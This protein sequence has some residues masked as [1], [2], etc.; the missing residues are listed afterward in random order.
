[1]NDM[2]V[3]SRGWREHLLQAK[4]DIRQE[5]WENARGA[6]LVAS[7]LRPG[8]QATEL[9]LE[10]V[11]EQAPAA[12]VVAEDDAEEGEPVAM[13]ETQAVFDESILGI[14]EPTPEAEVGNA[15]SADLDSPAMT[16]PSQESE[17]DEF[18]AWAEDVWGE[19]GEAPE[20]D[21]SRAESDQSAENDGVSEAPSQ[22]RTDAPVPSFEGDAA[23]ALRE[24][25]YGSDSRE[26]TRL[27]MR[28]VVQ[29]GY[30]EEAR[31]FVVEIL[32]KD[33][34]DAQAW[35][36]AGDLLNE[37]GE[38]DGAVQ[39]YQTALSIDPAV[40]IPSSMHDTLGIVSHDAGSETGEPGPDGDSGFGEIALD[41]ESQA[42]VN[43]SMDSA[44]AGAEAPRSDSDHDVSPITDT[45]RLVWSQNRTRP[46]VIRSVFSSYLD[47]EIS[48]EVRSFV[49]ENLQHRPEQALSW[50][51]AGDLLYSEGDADGAAEAFRTAHSMNAYLDT[52]IA[53]DR[54]IGRQRGSKMERPTFQESDGAQIVGAL[55]SE[56]DTSQVRDMAGSFTGIA[57]Q[58]AESRKA[59]VLE[60]LVLGS[61]SSLDGPAFTS[62]SDES[63]FGSPFGGQTAA[64]QAETI[65][66][67]LVTVWSD[68]PGH[69]EVTRALLRGYTDGGDTEGA[70]KFVRN[71]L[72]EQPENATAWAMAGDFLLIADRDYEAAAAAYLTAMSFDGDVWTPTA[73]VLEDP[74][75]S[76]GA[77]NEDESSELGSEWD[78]LFN[79]EPSPSDENQSP[80]AGIRDQESGG[81]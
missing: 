25:W 79:D 34:H 15:D 26:A 45:M 50:A 19:D 39:A 31:A 62:P 41:S 51:F 67:T 27:L 5:E 12:S 63:G 22:S 48:P 13:D 14:E 35:A 16:S 77:A 75:E 81:E 7:Q 32:G 4:I 8:T 58:E 74:A 54:R 66:A 33:A 55:L 59:L 49:V 23:Q 46:E 10:F 73:P 78:F 29:G 18:E 17:W 60:A 71:M 65:V 72:S 47:D 56:V 64:A 21:G 43:E 28:S 80:E 40:S 61:E 53:L 38:K 6:L 3:E 30:T 2:K 68:N 37:Q 70:V 69:P 44:T 11:N 9:L 42:T 76:T 1:M 36:I 57:L 52:P 20:D 24:S